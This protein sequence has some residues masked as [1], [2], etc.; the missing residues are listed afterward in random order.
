M[1][2]SA[3]RLRVT[4]QP[5]AVPTYVWL[6]TSADDDIWRQYQRSQRFWYQRSQRRC[7][8]TL[9]YCSCVQQRRF[10]I[11]TDMSVMV[12]RGVNDTLPLRGGVAPAK[13]SASGI[14]DSVLPDG[15]IITVGAKRFR[16][17]EVLFP[18]EDLRA[19]RQ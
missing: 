11:A 7:G 9:F 8:V 3:V 18:A 13:F 14:H 4:I 15:E 16:C 19:P 6:R 12:T 10:G 5:L 2:K 17:V 1:V